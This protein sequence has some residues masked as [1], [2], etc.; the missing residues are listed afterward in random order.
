[1]TAHLPCTTDPGLAARPAYAVP[2]RT[3]RRR[4]G[5]PR[6]AVAALERITRQRSAALGPGHL[7][8]LAARHQLAFFMG[9]A[10]SA[11]RILEPGH[12]HLRIAEEL[13]RELRSP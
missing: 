3:G 13:L 11:R 12:R 7:D 4:P 2:G 8:T 10:E 9:E 6:R 5:Q 1:M